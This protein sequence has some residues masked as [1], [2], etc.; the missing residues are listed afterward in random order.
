MNKI[1]LK[2]CKIL[3]IRKCYSMVLM[4]TFDIPKTCVLSHKLILD[5]V[6]NVKKCIFSSKTKHFKLSSRISSS[7]SIAKFLNFALKNRKQKV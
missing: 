6:L 1:D 3:E 2:F 7:N 5:S 4:F